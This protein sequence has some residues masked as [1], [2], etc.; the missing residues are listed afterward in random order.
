MAE[1]FYQRDPLVEEEK[2]QRKALQR[3]I[4]NTRAYNVNV[5]C[6]RT[7]GKGLGRTFGAVTF[8]LCGS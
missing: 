7:C 1:L 6:R 2:S 5:P 4:Y 3:E 8:D